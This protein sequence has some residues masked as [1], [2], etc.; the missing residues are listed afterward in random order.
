MRFVIIVLDGLRPDLVSAE[1]M[2][3]LMALRDSG[4]SFA[5]ARSTFPSETRVAT[6]SL[7]TG[8]RPGAHGLVANTMFVPGVTT[9][10]KLRTNQA[11]D[12]A[13]LGGGGS[14]L[15]RRTLG[16]HLAAA[17]R[18]LAVV[19]TGTAG[20]TVL[21]HPLAE[22]LGAFRWNVHATEG[23]AAERVREALGPTPPAA[24]PNNARI[25]FGADVMTRLVLPDLRPDVALLW[26]SEPDITF[27]AH[28]IG[29]AEAR[30]ALAAADDVVGQVRDWRDR[31]ADADAIGLIV[32][33]DHGH[34]TGS[35]R[36]DVTA[37][38]KADGFDVAGGFDSGGIIVTGGAAPGFYLSDPAQAADVAAFLARQ[39]WAGPLLVREP[40]LVAGAASLGMLGS[41]HER[42]PDIVALFRGGEAADGHG[43]PGSAPYDAGDVP[44]GGGMHGGLHRRELATVAVM[45]GGPFRRGAVVQ[46]F[47]DLSDMAPTLLH[48]LGVAAD[49]M[50]GRV[51]AEAWDDAAEPE[52]ARADVTLPHCF[53]LEAVRQDGRFY[54]I[55]LRET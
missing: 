28:G 13:L 23:A 19:S 27:H 40:G 32:L 41:A 1:T 22:R 10:R 37:E 9:R 25:A 52:P 53:T 44:V 30:A 50:D 26:C 21:S 14:P 33:S 42:S 55:G 12:L 4:T 29:S 47:A 2:P 8:C 24:A 6:S 18:A 11:A 45:Q 36:I 54:P 15:L 31:Q 35:R 16:E 46:A 34:V 5:N 49:D 20:S 3:Q 39:D 7:L 43:M 38:L 17:G 48:L 51:L